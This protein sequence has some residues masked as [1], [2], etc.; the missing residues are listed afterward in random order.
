MSNR[1]SVRNSLKTVV[2]ETEKIRADTE[3]ISR[4]LG[5]V[6]DVLKSVLVLVAKNESSRLKDEALRLKDESSRMKESCRNEPV[7]LKDE[8]KS[9]K[10]KTDSSMHSFEV[11][12]NHTVSFS[13]NQPNNGDN[14]I[15]LSNNPDDLRRT[16]YNGNPHIHVIAFSALPVETQQELVKL[17]IEYSFSEKQTVNIDDIKKV[18]EKYIVPNGSPIDWYVLV[19]LTIG[20]EKNSPLNIVGTDRIEL[21]SDH[22]FQYY[23]GGFSDHNC[24]TKF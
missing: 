6:L 5:E 23:D 20:F 4:T 8:S 3:K 10:L 2:S 12:K 15:Y 9:V 7:R 21:E 14:T 13:W 19:H 1:N 11:I 16:K 22:T 17:C 18:Y 24:M